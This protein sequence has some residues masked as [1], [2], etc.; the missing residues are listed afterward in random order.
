M[1]ILLIDL[2]AKAFWIGFEF[3]RMGAKVAKFKC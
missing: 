3:R 1:K 2:A